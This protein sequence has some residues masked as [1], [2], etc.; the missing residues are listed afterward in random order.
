MN[1]AA[2]LTSQ[3]LKIG[4]LLVFISTLLILQ[5]CQSDNEIV[6][7]IETQTGDTSI[8]S[9]KELPVNLSNTISEVIP[10]SDLKRKQQKQQIRDIQLD[11]NKIIRLVDSLKNTSYSIRFTLS[12]TPDNVFYN[13][14]VGTNKEGAIKKPYILKYII[15]NL[16]D[17]VNEDGF[18]NYSKMDATIERYSYKKFTR[19]VKSSKYKSREINDPCDTYNHNGS[20]SSS[21]GSGG[22][23]GSS[24]SFGNNTGTPSN[25]SSSGGS[26]S[27]GGGGSKSNCRAYTFSTPDGGIF[28]I[29]IYCDDGTTFFLRGGDDCIF[30]NG[31]G[32]GIN[33]PSYCPNGKTVNGE[34]VTAAWW[35]N[36]D[37]IVDQPK[38]P[39]KNVFEYLKCYNTNQSATITVYVAEPNPGSGDT[40][41]GKY[42]GHSY[43]SIKQGSEVSTFGFYPTSDHIYPVINNSSSSILGNDGSG[44]EIYTASIST[45]V[46]GNQLKKII[47]ASINHK[48][49]YNLNTYNCTDFAIDIGNIAGLNLPQANGKWPGGGGSNPGT[50]GLYIRNL[51]PKRNIVI[52]KKGGKSP[53]TK[54]TC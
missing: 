27:S 4:V 30:T 21:S 19:L 45:T 15:Y 26:I 20:S 46:S 50:L 40:Y 48:N 35:H 36:G 22:S 33:G 38:K 43:V 23:S 44:K 32:S 6:E 3:L 54:K 12:N 24:I 1:F 8:I 53:E 18:V 29:K 17:I 11:E 2:K 31:G 39:I 47:N 14:I 28:A 9:L 10:F 34:C 52:N 49:N 41:N 25:S 7:Q 42:V 51:N 37:V 5:N 13:L 16:D